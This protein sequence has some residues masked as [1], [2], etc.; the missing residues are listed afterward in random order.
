MYLPPEDRNS[1]LFAQLAKLQSAAAPA[2]PPFAR[3]LAV[4]RNEVAHFANAGAAQPMQGL[5]RRS[6][7]QEG[8]AR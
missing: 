4:A 6:R 5:Q 7:L 3:E 1:A 8:V 2:R